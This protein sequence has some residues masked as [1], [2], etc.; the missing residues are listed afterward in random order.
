MIEKKLSNA[1]PLDDE[2]VVL[3]RSDNNFL[4]KT[5]ITNCILSAPNGV[6][7]YSG[8]TIT[9]KQGLKILI[10]NGRNADKTLNN[11]EN[12]LPNDI[13]RDV[14]T[15]PNGTY[16]VLVN[17]YEEVYSIDYV[18]LKTYYESSVKPTSSTARRWLDTENNYYYV[19]D[20]GTQKQAFSIKVLTFVLKDGQITA[21]FPYQPVELAMQQDIDGVWTAGFYQIVQQLSLAPNERQ[22]YDVS[23]ALPSDGQKYECM[24]SLYGRTSTTANTSIQI[25]VDTNGVGVIALYTTTLNS[26]YMATGS[27]FNIIVG[28]DRKIMLSAVNQNGTATGIGMRITAYRK[29]R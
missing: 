20:T 11:I 29:V 21:L 3:R 19:L 22:T 2:N 13:S 1:T 10:P 25:W 5:Q 8:S 16:I 18:L 24:V 28:A 26:N 4:N 27:T 12:I 7:T 23:A 6:A 17:K 15:S 14:G 9:I